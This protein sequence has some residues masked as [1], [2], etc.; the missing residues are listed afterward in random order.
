MYTDFILFSKQQYTLYWQRKVL[1]CESCLFSSWVWVCNRIK[2]QWKG[3]YLDHQSN[4]RNS[5]ICR[6]I[7][8]VNTVWYLLIFCS[9]TA[10]HFCHCD[11]IYF[12]PNFIMMHTVLYANELFALC[13]MYPVLSISLIL[14][15]HQNIKNRIFFF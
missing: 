10:L 15:R 6:H 2:W 12:F 7:L 5:K 13:W 8:H 11:F 1:A 4:M 3:Q 14:T 9:F